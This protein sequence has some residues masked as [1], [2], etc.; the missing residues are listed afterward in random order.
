MG[1]GGEDTQ[2]CRRPIAITRK[3]T[4][5]PRT[6]IQRPANPGSQRGGVAQPISDIQSNANEWEQ[7]EQH[8]V[9]L[10]RI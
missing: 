5:V 6:R 7:R 4:P 10:E 9:Y 3:L 2:Q 1:R 8:A